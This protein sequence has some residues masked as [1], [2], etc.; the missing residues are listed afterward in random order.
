MRKWEYLTVKIGRVVKGK[1]LLKAHA[2]DSDHINS[3]LNSYGQQGWE[4]V[5]C[6]EDAWQGTVQAVIAIL[7]REVNS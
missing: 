6:F 4:L 7:K 1:G 3:A 5:S 2:F